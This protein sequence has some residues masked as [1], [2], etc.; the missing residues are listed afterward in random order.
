[1]Q[2]NNHIDIQLSHNASSVMSKTKSTISSKNRINWK[3]IVNVLETYLFFPMLDGT[4]HISQLTQLFR[5]YFKDN[6]VDRKH[7]TNQISAAYYNKNDKS[8]IF[9]EILSQKLNYSLTKRHQFYHILLHHFIKLSELNEDNIS[10]IL[11]TRF[12]ITCKHNKYIKNIQLNDIK[13]IINKQQ[14]NG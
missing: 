9:Y 7:F 10:K 1:M 2:R 5:K 3:K 8:F 6:N 11:L 12:N 14:I 13:E 4:Q